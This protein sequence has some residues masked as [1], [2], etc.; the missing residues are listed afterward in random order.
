MHKTNLQNTS[1]VYHAVDS[2]VMAWIY[3]WAMLDDLPAVKNVSSHHAVQPSVFRKLFEIIAVI[4]VDR[5]IVCFLNRRF[6]EATHMVWVYLRGAHT[7]SSCK[8]LIK[9]TSDLPTRKMQNIYLLINILRIL[10]TMYVGVP[11]IPT[12]AHLAQHYLCTFL[13]LPD[14]TLITCT[15][16]N[17][18]RC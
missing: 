10:S 3:V 14:F 12:W 2:V 6:V 17:Q 8:L 18:P 13:P 4:K 7:S 5:K 9:W 11:C 15:E 16:W 1:M